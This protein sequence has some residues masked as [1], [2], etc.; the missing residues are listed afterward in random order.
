MGYRGAR[1]FGV[2]MLLMGIIGCGT[3]SASIERVYDVSGTI[4]VDGRPL[5]QGM[6]LF[7]PVDGSGG[8]SMT[9]VE[10]GAFGCAIAAGA[11]E[12]HIEDLRTGKAFGGEKQP[13]AVTVSPGADNR[14]D[15][16]IK[17]SGHPSK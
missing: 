17:S 12:V 9:M 14:F 6:V 4:R 10:N 8:S 16:D 2:A 7:K 5:A 1:S 13:L 11:K 3:R 15:F